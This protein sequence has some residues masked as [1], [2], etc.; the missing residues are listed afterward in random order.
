MN[1]F[2]IVKLIIKQNKKR[3]LWKYRKK[4]TKL[5]ELIHGTNFFYLNNN[6]IIESSNV[7]LI[8]KIF[9]K[10]YEIVGVKNWTWY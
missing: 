7:I 5:L 1:I 6:I 9:F 3:I 4:N 10:I 8:K 2:K